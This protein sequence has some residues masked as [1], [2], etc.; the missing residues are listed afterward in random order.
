MLRSEIKIKTNCSA[1]NE[2]LSEKLVEGVGLILK[3]IVT[4][5][6]NTDQ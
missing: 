5:L 1:K 4:K 2:E 3:R 6:K